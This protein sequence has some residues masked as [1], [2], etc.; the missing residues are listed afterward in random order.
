MEP[1]GCNCLELLANRNCVIA[2]PPDPALSGVYQHTYGGEA[3]NFKYLTGKD[4]IKY[5]GKDGAVFRIAKPKDAPTIVSS[6]Y[7]MW[8]RY[9]VVLKPAPGAGI[10][11]SIVLQSDN[12]DEIDWVC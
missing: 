2:C 4:V 9:E 1:V 11:S 5:G 12:L 10:I 3:P 6:F 7:I 8:G